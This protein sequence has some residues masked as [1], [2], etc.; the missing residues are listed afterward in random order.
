MPWQPSHIRVFSFPL[1]GSPF[2]AAAGAGVCAAA[3][4]EM[5]NVRAAIAIAQYR[6]IG[7]SMSLWK[8]ADDAARVQSL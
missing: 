8:G 1:A 7:E 6:I 4:A 2:A 5:V 3:T